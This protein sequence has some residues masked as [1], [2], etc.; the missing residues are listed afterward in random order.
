VPSNNLFGIVQKKDIAR[1]RQPFTVGEVLQYIEKNDDNPKALAT[2][3]DGKWKRLSTKEF[4]EEIKYTALGL[5]AL[6]VQRGEHIGLLAIPCNRWTV[7][8]F[9]IMAAG[10]ISVP[11]FANIST[12]HFL[13]EVKEPNISKI[14]VSGEEQWRRI[15]DHHDLFEKIFSLDDQ[16][17]HEKALSYDG[18]LKLG[19]EYDES[20]PGYYQELLNSIKPTEIATI[21]YTSGSTGVP[22][23][24]VHTHRSISSLLPID[25]FQWDPK[26]DSFLSFLPLAHVFA[27]I[28]NLT[29]ISWGIPVY[30]YNDIK[31]LGN[32]CKE[33]HP[34]IIIVVPRVLEKMYAKMWAKIQEGSFLK[35]MIGNY[36]F[37]LAHQEKKS[38]L[39]PLIDFL[40]YKH[41][42]EALGGH[43][44]VVISGGAALN[45]RLCKFFLNAG[46]PI[47]EG[48]GLTESC[49]VTVNC[50]GKVRVGT[51]GPPLPGMLVRV[52]EG[53]ELL[54][55]GEML[56]KGYYGGGEKVIDQEGWLH[57]GDKGMI[58]QEGFVTLIG[59]IKELFKTSTGEIVAPVPIEQ[60]LS[61]ASWIEI[62]MVIADNRKFV[63]CLIFPNFE[64]LKMLKE[65]AGVS[66]MGDEAFLQG[67]DMKGEMR[68]LLESVN[69]NLNKWEQIH[70]YKIVPYHLS[71]ET[72][73]LTPSMKLKREVVENKF[74]DLIDF[75][76]KEVS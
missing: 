2:Y 25:V 60:A 40:V 70:D 44:R 71:V 31:T 65:K 10:A 58:D 49:P 63:S 75:I 30:Y 12:E 36:A 68:S 28:F 43:L 37:K 41:L 16:A 38:F 8:D 45:P 55:S 66:Q 54:V 46:F 73:E 51:I 42:R 56:M 26:K 50:I 15:Q 5:I 27:R 64:A 17:G 32:A 52:G 39:T 61:K 3:I 6:R 1:M 24:A 7:A 62:P 57:T 11:I 13:F 67:D 19:K 34:T 53:G 4:L 72:G 18:L 59:R 21:I 22:K 33:V 23:G 35:R 48:W 20:R 29:M 76:Y 74:S 47:Y 69:S 14:F 9:A